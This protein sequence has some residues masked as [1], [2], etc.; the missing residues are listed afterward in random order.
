[1]TKQLKWIVAAGLLAASAAANAQFSSTI[2]ATNDYDFR[3]FSQSAKDPAI[4]AS[5]DYAFPAGFAIGAW[6]SNID[7][8]PADGDVE[9]DLYGSYTG[10]INDDNSW[11]IGFTYY[12]YPGSDDLGEYPEYFLGYNYKNFGIKQWYADDF[13]ESGESAEYTEAN[14]TFPLPNSFSLLAH[15]GYSWGDYWDLAGGELFDY[16]VGV[17]YT[18]EKLNFALKFNG[19][20]PSGA[21]KVTGDVGNNEGRVVFTVSTT[22]PW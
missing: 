9:L 21:Q 3:G 4:Q 13:Y 22:L 17:G 1:M 11:S 10:K 19:T 15:V 16:S 18:Y 12:A 2:T 5:L 7:F 6:A 8:S 20:A 14:A